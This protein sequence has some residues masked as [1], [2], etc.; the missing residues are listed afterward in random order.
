MKK[1]IFLLLISFLLIGCGKKVDLIGTW[2]AS[3]LTYIFNEDGT[4]TKMDN[5]SSFS[6]TYEEKDGIINIYLDNKD[7]IYES[8]QINPDLLIIGSNVY[9]KADN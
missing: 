8:G 7:E 3:N 9:K 4:C 1:I 6:C 2:N 5:T